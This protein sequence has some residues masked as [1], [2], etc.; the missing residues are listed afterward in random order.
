LSK[1]SN[2]GLRTL[3]YELSARLDDLVNAYFAERI[4][5]LDAV[6]APAERA[7]KQELMDK[8]IDAEFRSSFEEDW[9]DLVDE[10]HKRIGGTTYLP[11]VADTG[12]VDS[13]FISTAANNLTSF[14]KQ[15]P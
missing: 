14:A 2:E 9:N 7:A 12:L 1:V 10:L 8:I 11:S 15:L 3:A 6:K 4:K 13:G 5:M